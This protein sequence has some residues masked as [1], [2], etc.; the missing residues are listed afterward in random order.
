MKNTQE[1]ICD[2]DLPPPLLYCPFG[3]TKHSVEIEKENE[4]VDES[5][6]KWNKIPVLPYPGF[7]PSEKNQDKLVEKKKLT[8]YRLKKQSGKKTYSNIT[9]RKT[10]VNPYPSDTKTY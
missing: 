2:Y 5:V 7:N 9:M 8:Y 10:A 3:L 6:F 4:N 1:I